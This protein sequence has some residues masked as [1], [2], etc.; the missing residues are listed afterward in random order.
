MLFWRIGWCCFS[1][2]CI[3]S[4]RI[5]LEKKSLVMLG[6]HAF[7]AYASQHFLPP[8]NHT[9]VHVSGGKKCQCF[10]KILYTYKM[11]D[12]KWI[13]NNTSSL[14]RGQTFSRITEFYPQKRKFCC[15]C[16]RC[17]NSS[18]CAVVRKFLY[19]PVC[20]SMFLCFPTRVL[21][22]QINDLDNSTNEYAMQ[23]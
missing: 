6:D 11:K 2:S 5:L 14:F 20:Q 9:Y 16:Q 13:Y 15:I 3:L 1:V 17:S 7:S 22:Y 23:F 21:T 10:W 12:P 4:L 18:K 8:V 19:A